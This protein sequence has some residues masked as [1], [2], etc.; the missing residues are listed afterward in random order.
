QQL[1]NAAGDVYADRILIG[2]NPLS[3][4]WKDELALLNTG[5]EKLKQQRLNF[6]PK[7]TVKT[8]PQYKPS[9]DAD[10]SR[11]FTISHKAITSA[12]VGQPVT[13]K[14][15]VSAPAGLKWVRLQYRAVNQYKDFEMLPM[16]ATAEKDTFQATIPADRIDSKYNLMYLVEMMDKNGKGFIYPDFNKVTPYNIISLIRK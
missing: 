2:K 15:K 14:I 10:N 11:Y 16:T 3:G 8:T 6:Q 12:A 9:A 4:H 1:V 7:G 5:L 13:I